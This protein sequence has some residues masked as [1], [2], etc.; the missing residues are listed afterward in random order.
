MQQAWAGSIFGAARILLGLKVTVEGDDEVEPGPMIVLVRH[1]SILD[2][3]LPSVFVARAHRIRLRY[4]LKRELLN[5]PGLDIGGKRIP[6]YFVRRG[7]GAEVVQVLTPAAAAA[8]GI[9]AVVEL[10]EPVLTQHRQLIYLKI[11]GQRCVA[12][13]PVEADITPHSR[14]H[15]QIDRQNIHLFDQQTGARIG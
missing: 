3:L 10:V 7:T 14:I 2:N 8:T 6:N 5:D 15:V 4:L 9:P 12:S 1:A 13:L 11:A